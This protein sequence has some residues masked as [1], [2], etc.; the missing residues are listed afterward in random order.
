M[1]GVQRQFL[2]LLEADGRFELMAPPRFGLTCF[3]I[4]V[5]PSVCLRPTASSINITLTHAEMILLAM[6]HLLPVVAGLP[7]EL[8]CGAPVA[9][10]QP[11][12]RCTEG[13]RASSWHVLL[14]LQL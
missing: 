8:V 3:A 2:E 14:L 10:R 6:L 11:H 1:L 4:K 12:N 9:R 7:C 5:P 13:I